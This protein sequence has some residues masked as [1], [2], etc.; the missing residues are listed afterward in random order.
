MQSQEVQP[1]PITFFRV[2]NACA[3]LAALEDSRHVHQQMIQSNFE[4][5]VFVGSSLIDMY[6]KCGSIDDA[7]RVFNR[8]PTQDVVSWSVMILGHVKVWASTKGIGTILRNAMQRGAAKMV[9]SLM[10][11]WVIDLLTCTPN[12]GA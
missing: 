7:W 10:Y 2:V 11:L 12:V 8:M 6:A 3:S 1:A 9:M 5:D 4:T